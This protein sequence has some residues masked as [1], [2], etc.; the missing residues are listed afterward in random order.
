M[1]GHALIAYVQPRFK[2]LKAFDCL[3]YCFM[4]DVCRYVEPENGKV[5]AAETEQSFQM[6]FDLLCSEA[7]RNLGPKLDLVDL[8]I[9]AVCAIVD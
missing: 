8:F 2:V 7:L 4:N 3:N 5:R 6:R 9:P 1:R